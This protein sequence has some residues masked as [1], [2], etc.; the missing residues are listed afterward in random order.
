MFP[1]FTISDLK[2][3]EQNLG[4]VFQKIPWKV[5]RY[6]MAYLVVRIY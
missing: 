4:K 6:L 5:S 1:G 2:F 3:T